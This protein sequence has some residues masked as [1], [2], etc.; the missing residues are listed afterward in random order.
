MSYFYCNSIVSPALPILGGWGR[1]RK[2]DVCLDGLQAMSKLIKIK[3]PSFLW[4]DFY[5]FL[6][7]NP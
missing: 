5:G 7:I 2:G 1:N 3:N 4:R 6:F